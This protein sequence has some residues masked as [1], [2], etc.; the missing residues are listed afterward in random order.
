M[1]N[2][3]SDLTEY[4]RNYLMNI[5][6]INKVHILRSEGRWM[7]FLD[8]LGIPMYEYFINYKDACYYAMALWVNFKNVR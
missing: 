4:E 1:Q 2:Y 3:L 7:V 6:R 8:V 5:E